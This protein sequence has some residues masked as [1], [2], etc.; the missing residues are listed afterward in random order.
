MGFWAVK[1][2]AWRTSNTSLFTFYK[3]STGF[4]V[5]QTG[6]P[7]FCRV[8][9]GFAVIK[10]GLTAPRTCSCLADLLHA[11]NRLVGS[12]MTDPSHTFNGL[13][14]SQKM[15][16]TDFAAVKTGLLNL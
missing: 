16:L 1:N 15:P 12:Q 8:S 13:R 3:P 11:F 9:T 6:L 4:A 2:L 14:I 5:L 7:N 10:M